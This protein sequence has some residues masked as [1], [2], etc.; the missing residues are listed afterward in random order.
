MAYYTRVETEAKR[1][2]SQFFPLQ[3]GVG[4]YLTMR[5]WGL[6]LMFSNKIAHFV[7]PTV[8]KIDNLS[9]KTHTYEEVWQ[10]SKAGIDKPPEKSN[11]KINHVC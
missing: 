9:S 4:I 5:L 2:T 11:E 7:Y 6:I 10:T 3:A 1:K 8:R